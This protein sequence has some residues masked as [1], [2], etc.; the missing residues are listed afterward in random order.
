MREAGLPGF[1]IT[2]WHALYAPRGTAPA[3]VARLSAAP[4]RLWP[5]PRS[6]PAFAD[7]G[8]VLFPADRRGPGRHARPVR[9]EVEKWERVIREAG[10]RPQ[11]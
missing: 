10:F 5:S 11:P 7:L 9:N 4:R 6:S 1:E 8:T 2:Q 3:I